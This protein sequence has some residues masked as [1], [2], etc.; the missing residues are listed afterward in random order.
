MHEK[1]IVMRNDSRLFDVATYCVSKGLTVPIDSEKIEKV[2][3]KFVEFKRLVKKEGMTI[4][5]IES[6]VYK[7]YGIMNTPDENIENFLGA[8]AGLDKA[9]RERDERDEDH[10]SNSKKEKD[11]GA[12]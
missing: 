1:N 9:L 6:D 11:E 5:R 4:A 12:S 3:I 8:V 10:K 2:H 7:K